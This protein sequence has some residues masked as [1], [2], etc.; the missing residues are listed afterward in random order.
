ME[1]EKWERSRK[2]GC[3]W[4]M[5]VR[6]GPCFTLKHTRFRKQTKRSLKLSWRW[7]MKPP[8]LQHNTCSTVF[9][10]YSEHTTTN[11]T[12]RDRREG[13]GRYPSLTTSLNAP[14]IRMKSFS[15]MGR[16]S[17]QKSKSLLPFLEHCDDHASFNYAWQA[18]WQ[19][20]WSSYSFSSRSLISSSL[21]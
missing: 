12:R 18:H 11:A 2:K 6:C 21:S 7:L 14:L 17:Y 13:R 15:S 5:G 16:A 4:G 20:H 19:A 3:R 10:I 8:L 9:W 1:G